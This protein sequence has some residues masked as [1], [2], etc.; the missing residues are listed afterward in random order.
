VGGWH[1]KTGMVLR[2]RDKKMLDKNI[3]NLEHSIPSRVLEKIPSIKEIDG[4]LRLCHF[5]TQCAHESGNFNLVRENLNY[6][7]A[8]LLNLFGKYFPD[9]ETALK[10]ARKPGKIANRVYANRYGNG[11]EL[12]GDGW[13][14]RGRGYLQLTFKNNYQDFSMYIKDDCTSN[15]DLVA[16]KYPLQSAA[17]FFTIN[18]LWV[19]CDRGSMPSVIELITRRVNGGT[20]GLD[21]RIKLF[22]AFYKEATQ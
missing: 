22:N 11:D 12:S 15:P 19:L 10:Y 3:K 17:W 7:P 6:G 18:N 5:L 4:P 16:D 20:N 13:K 1:Q 2:I 9:T 21:G 14:Y 8:G